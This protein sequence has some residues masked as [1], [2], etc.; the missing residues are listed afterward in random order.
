MK[1]TPIADRVLILRKE[2]LKEKGGLILVNETEVIFEGTVIEVG[3]GSSYD[4]MTVK[5]GDKV[6]H[7][8]RAGTELTIEGKTYLMMRQRDIMATIE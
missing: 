8:P 4:T 1:V 6:I 2:R 3:P 5:P 7:A